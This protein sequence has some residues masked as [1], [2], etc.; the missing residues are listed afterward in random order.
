VPQAQIDTAGSIIPMIISK[1]QTPHSG[2]EPHVFT[3]KP[4]SFT[5]TVTAIKD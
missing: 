4:S 3:R 1:Y 2:K 5:T